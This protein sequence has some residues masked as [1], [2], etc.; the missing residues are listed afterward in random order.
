MGEPADQRSVERSGTGPATLKLAMK[1]KVT[2]T[3]NDTLKL[4]REFL[5]SA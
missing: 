3:V 2:F 1:R 5:Q 4:S